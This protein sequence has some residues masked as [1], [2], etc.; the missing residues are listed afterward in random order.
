MATRDPATLTLSWFVP[1]LLDRPA[2]GTS[3][4]ATTAEA[5]LSSE[6]FL[7]PGVLDLTVDV[8]LAQI[9]VVTDP[10]RIDATAV[11]TALVDIGYPPEVDKQ[12]PVRTL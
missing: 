6:L 10:A 3:C 8:G 9:V 5:L 12:A 4:C 2:V 7:L 11:F 1:G